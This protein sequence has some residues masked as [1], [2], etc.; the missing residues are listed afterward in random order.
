[1]I[2]QISETW[3]REW[4][5][6]RWESLQLAQRLTMAG[7]EVEGRAPAAPAFNGVV[8]GAIVECRKHPQADKLSVC[9]VTTDG[10]NRLQIVCGASNARAG[11]K[12]AVA[13]V[14]AKL[15]GDVTIQRTPLRDV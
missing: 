2:V 3:L 12:S 4:V 9:S 14:G 5:N 6:P 11:L 13:L 8:V 1:L 7:F 10:K 15:P